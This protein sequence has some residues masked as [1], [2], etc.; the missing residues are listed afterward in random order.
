MIGSLRA[1]RLVCS[2]LHAQAENRAPMLCAAN[3]SDWQDAIALANEHFIT[4]ALYGSLADAG[5]LKLLPEDVRGYLELLWRSNIARNRRIRHQALQLIGAFA[6]ANIAVMLL[7]GGARLFLDRDAD[8][9]GR[10]VRDIDVLVPKERADD[11]LA[12]L[13]ALGYGIVE[14]YPPGH[15]AY[16]DFVR[17]GEPAAI[18]LHFELIDTP[19]VLPA[20]D[21]RRRAVPVVAGDVTFFVPSATDRILHNVLHAQIH[22]LASYY[23]GLIELRQLQE[24]ATIARR[25]RSDIDWC[26]IDAHLRR[27]RLAVPL[28]AYAWAAHC[29][30][31][32]PWMLPRLPPIRARL[33]FQRYLLQYRMP[34]LAWLAIPVANLR[35]AFASFRMDGMYAQ[36]GPMLVRRLRHAARFLRKGNAADWIARLLR[37]PAHPRGW[38]R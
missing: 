29:L 21:V 9:S 3:E 34:V 2:C 4:P 11:V 32:A 14:R 37:S 26:L 17:P 16:G 31:G 20:D 35:S 22:F 6:R 30:L 25:D 36:Q 12:V 5:Q 15:H 23:R 28:H 7:K 10:M 33:H 18:D 1:L 24:F 27:H 8:R 38:R 13:D 19:H